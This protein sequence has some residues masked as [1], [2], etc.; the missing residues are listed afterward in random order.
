MVEGRHVARTIGAAPDAGSRQ[1]APGA[2]RRDYADA[3]NWLCY[4]TEVLDADEG[5]HSWD[6]TVTLIQ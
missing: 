6:K 4:G 5:W 2:V 3:Y 1:R